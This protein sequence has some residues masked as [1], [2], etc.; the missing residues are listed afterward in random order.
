MAAKRR[1]GAS[2]RSKA[3]EAPVERDVRG[4]LIRVNGAGLRALRQLA[5]DQDRSLQSLGVEA[6]NNLLRKYSY[7]PVVANPLHPAE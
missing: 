2:A 1:S 7:K 6:F 4:V 5:L 3:D